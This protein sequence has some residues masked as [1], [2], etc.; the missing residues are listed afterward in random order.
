[1]KTPLLIVLTAVVVGVGSTLAIMNNSCKS[2]ITL[3]ALQL[4]TSDTTQRPDWARRFARRRCPAHGDRCYIDAVGLYF[5]NTAAGSG[6]KRVGCSG[7]KQ[8]VLT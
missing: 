5:R 2:A 4:R 3:G 8:K 1:M 7:S 6:E